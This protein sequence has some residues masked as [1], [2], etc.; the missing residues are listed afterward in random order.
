MSLVDVDVDISGFNPMTEHEE[1]VTDLGFC[2]I[3]KP[4]PLISVEMPTI[5]IALESLVGSV[6]IDGPIVDLDENFVSSA[7]V[8]VSIPDVS[9]LEG[10]AVSCLYVDNEEF[11]GR[12][13]DDTFAT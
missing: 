1:R 7:N 10:L 3:C 8:S 9:P 12:L 6:L 2:L 5:G 11:V 4:R 13:S